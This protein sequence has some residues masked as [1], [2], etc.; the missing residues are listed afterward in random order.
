MAL[1]FLGAQD[2]DQERQLVSS[3][4][5]K[6]NA[7]SVP[8]EMEPYEAQ[9]PGSTAKFEMVPISGG[10][11][12]MGSPPDEADRR[13]DEGEQRTVTVDSFWMGAHEVTWDLYRLFMFSELADEAE[14][15]AQLVDGVRR[16]TPPYVEMSFGMGVEGDPAISMTQH[17]AAKFTQWLSAKTGQ[18]YRLPTEA[19]WEKSSNILLG[20]DGVQEDKVEEDGHD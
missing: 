8:A 1:A 12:L 13:E 17:A 11:F 10:E 9:I 18:F 20:Q 14:A 3:L 16:P 4:H 5:A 6:I 19:E 15:R 2:T 7:G